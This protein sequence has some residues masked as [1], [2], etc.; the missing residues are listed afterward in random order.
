MHVLWDSGNPM[1]VLDV[2]D[3]L[4]HKKWEYRTVATLLIRMREK[5]GAI[6]IPY[7]GD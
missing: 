7:A 5:G 2:C 1:K 6:N 3:A 4:T